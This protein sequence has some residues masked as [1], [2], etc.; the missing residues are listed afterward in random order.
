MRGCSNVIIWSVLFPLL[1]ASVLSANVLCLLVMNGLGLKVGWVGGVWPASLAVCWMMM[2]P[3][4]VRQEPFRTPRLAWWLCA[5]ALALLTAPRLTYLAEWIPGA[6]VLAQADDYGRLAELISLTQ[7]PNYPL[8]HAANQSFLLSHYYTALYPM[9]WLKSVAPK[10]TLKDCIVAGNLLYHVLMLGAL[11]QCA[12]RLVRRKRGAVMLVFLFTL[13]GGLDVLVGY[14]GLFQHKE[15]W[16]ARFLGCPRQISSFYTASFW[17]VHH[18]AAAWAAII[19]YVLA[20]ETRYAKPWRK[21]LVLGWLLVTVA[22]TSAYAALT[23]PLLAWREILVV[24]RRLL[25]RPALMLPLGAAAAMPVW[26]ALKRVDSNGFFWNEPRWNVLYYV[27]AI[28]VIDLVGIP[29]WAAAQWRHLSSQERRWLVGLGVFLL[30]TW[31]LESAGFNN[32]MM[33][34]GLVPVAA[35]MVILARR[36]SPRWMTALVLA[37][38][39]TTVQEAATMTYR[40]LMYSN[41][42]WQ[43]RGLEMPLQTKARMRERYAQI[44]RDPSIA[45]YAPDAGDR[46]GMDKYNA[47]KMVRGLDLEEMVSAEREIARRR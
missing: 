42:Y 19:A 34:G 37:T 6:V 27:A 36:D 18:M 4:R 32:Y 7:S 45:Y 8:V 40:C 13:Y 39:L 15:T 38:T 47:E 44:A 5:A 31:G 14:P 1:L 23:L 21:A 10:L 43:S 16:A 9:A 24:V 2:R 33:R 17:T 30:S 46:R 20:K 35:L 29:F 11:A 22:A 26:L 28:C 3:A 41:W 12:P 25:R